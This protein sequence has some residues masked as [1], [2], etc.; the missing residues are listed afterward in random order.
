MARVESTRADADRAELFRATY[1]ENY[2]PILGYALR[3]SST[4]DDAADVVAETFLVLWRRFDSAPPAD[5][6]RPWLYGIARNVIANKQRATRRHERLR[7]R[8]NAE[9]NS[10]RGGGWDPGSDLVFRALNELSPR[11]RELLRLAAW[12][13]LTPRELSLTLGCTVNAA[14]IRLHRAR[15]RLAHQLEDR[16]M[17]LKPTARTGHVSVDRPITVPNE[18]DIS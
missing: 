15:R 9:V 5:E 10:P 6:V 1:E 4:P 7:A 13:G 2:L 8:L 11:D 17:G 14:K 12:E 16:G 18:E 3:R